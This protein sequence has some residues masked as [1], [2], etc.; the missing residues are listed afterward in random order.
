MPLLAKP[1][2]TLIDHTR[3]V[4]KVFTSMSDVLKL[5]K[6]PN[7]ID[8]ETSL[9]V[10][11]VMHDIG[12]AASG[13]QYMLEKAAMHERVR[14]EYRHEILSGA[15]MS[16]LTFEQ[17]QM[18]QAAALA[19]ITHHKD[20]H[21]LY[22]SYNPGRKSSPG[23]KR[24]KDRLLETKQNLPEIID[25]V[26]TLS[27]ELAQDYPLASRI[28]S[29]FPSNPDDLFTLALG[30]EPI[31]KYALP[32]LQNA[33]LRTPFLPKL[34]G[35]LLKGV[36]TASDHL[37][38][39]SPGSTIRTLNSNIQFTKYAPNEAQIWTSKLSGSGI[40]VAPTG[41]G[42]TE[43]SLL[44]FKNNM[45]SNWIRRVFYLLPTIASIN[46]MYLRLRN[47]IS[48]GNQNDFDLV[49]MA[50]YRSSFFLHDFYSNDNYHREEGLRKHLIDISR[51]VYSPLRVTTPFQPLKAIF[52]VAGFERVLTE[53]MGSLIVVDEI[54]AYDPHTS[55]LIL[56]M[57]EVLKQDYGANMLLMSATFPTF[58]RRIFQVALNIDDPAIKQVMNES[59]PPRHRLVLLDGEVRDNIDKIKNCISE[60]KT[61]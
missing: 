17:E 12:K 15:F 55:A 41:S 11:I 28:L 21:K 26:H 14:W 16:A 47:Q 46:K 38:S 37:G 9:A 58:L 5:S 30:N 4:L 8:I 61:L 43:A 45:Q 56:V 7:D 50:H 22:S 60:H 48:G 40:L 13:F 1:N 35:V 24:F 52:G 6:I 42:K 51:M 54:H 3:D 18:E 2:H 10:A 53:L 34:V 59:K 27:T 49:S 57:L 29:S 36:M 19:T 20:L 44:W 31:G 25:L 39:A 23:Y 33:K 32:Y